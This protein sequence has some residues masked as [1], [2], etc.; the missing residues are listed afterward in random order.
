MYGVKE[1]VRNALVISDIGM[2]NEVFVKQFDAFYARRVGF[3]FYLLPLQFVKLFFS[4]SRDALRNHLFRM[5]WI[6]ILE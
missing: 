1:G 4:K 6:T 3:Q 2:I 5:T